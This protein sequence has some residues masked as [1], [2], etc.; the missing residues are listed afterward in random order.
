MERMHAYYGFLSVIAGTKQGLTLVEREKK[1]IKVT[2]TRTAEQTLVDTTHLLA[3]FS[4]GI[5]SFRLINIYLL[6]IIS[7]ST[8]SPSMLR[9]NHQK[10]KQKIQ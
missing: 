6:I 10:R 7:P 5:S 3:N 8:L 9:L 2:K 4:E 1:N